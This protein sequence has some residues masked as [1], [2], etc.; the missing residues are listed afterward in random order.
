MRKNNSFIVKFKKIE[1][2][3]VLIKLSLV[4]LS[5]DKYF[6]TTLDWM[7][8]H[9]MVIPSPYYTP[10][11]QH[12]TPVLNSITKNLMYFLQ[13]AFIDDASK[14]GDLVKKFGFQKE[15]V[16]TLKHDRCSVFICLKDDLKDA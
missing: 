1:T 9:C 13:I 10:P 16:M 12:Y 2:E 14:V 3:K 11:P 7:P 8:V 15:D 4:W 6:F 5:D